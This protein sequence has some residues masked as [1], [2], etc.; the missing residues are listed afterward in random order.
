MKLQRSDGEIFLRSWTFPKKEV[1]RMYWQSRRILLW[2][3]GILWFFTIGK[4]SINWDSFT[5]WQ[6]SFWC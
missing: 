2:I 3:L 6:H 4:Y 5:R 1:I